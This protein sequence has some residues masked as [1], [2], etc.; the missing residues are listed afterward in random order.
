MPKYRAYVVFDAS[1]HAG[2]FIA[3]D[4]EQAE[5]M[6]WEDGDYH[7]SIC[8]HCSDQFDFGDPIKMIIEEVDDQ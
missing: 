1:K 2:D 6:A 7:V 3:D 5:E 8:H 4:K